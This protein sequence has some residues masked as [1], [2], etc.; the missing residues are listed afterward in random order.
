MAVETVAD[1]LRVALELADAG[2]ALMRQNLRR[3]HPG[4]SNEEIER[5]LIDW[6]G[7]RPGA[8]AGDCPGPVRR[9]ASG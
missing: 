7:R 2:F 4:A 8:S 9:L 3:A 5:L 1:R 6:I